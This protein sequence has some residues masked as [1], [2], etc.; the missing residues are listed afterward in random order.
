MMMWFINVVL[1]V[2]DSPLIRI[3]LAFAK[4]LTINPFST[5]LP[6]ATCMFGFTFSFKIIFIVLL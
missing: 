6:K 5:S 4:F 2:P 3:G 1:P